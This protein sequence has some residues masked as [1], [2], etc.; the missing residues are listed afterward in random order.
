MNGNIE[1]ENALEL[2]EFLKGFTGSTATFEVRPI[3]NG[4]YKLTFTGGC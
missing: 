3:T 2:G 1:F 4:R